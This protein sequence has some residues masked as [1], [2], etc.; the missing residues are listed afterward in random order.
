MLEARTSCSSCAWYSPMESLH[1]QRSHGSTLLLHSSA[2][3]ASMRS[4]ETTTIMNCMP[5]ESSLRHSSVSVAI[6]AATA[7]AETLMPHQQHQFCKEE[8]SNSNKLHVYSNTR[9][10]GNTCDVNKCDGRQCCFQYNQALRTATEAFI[11]HKHCQQLCHSH[12]ANSA[13]IAVSLSM[14]M[15]AWTAAAWL[16]TMTGEG[17]ASNITR[18]IV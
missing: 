6:V 14:E 11:R 2:D 1:Q 15:T 3:Q 4:V 8:G 13:A 7:S 18:G 17:T 10:H 12:F 5:I 9:S 16:P